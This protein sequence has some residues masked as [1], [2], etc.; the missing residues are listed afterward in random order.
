MKKKLK[1]YGYCDN[2][3]VGFYR[4]WSIL[5]MLKK[6]DLAEVKTAEYKWSEGDVQFP[7]ID[8]LADIGEWADI[9][10]FQRHDLG[11]YIA[12]FG[13]LSELFNI[14]FILE[15]DDNVRFVRPWNP[16]YRGYNPQGEALIWHRKV[17]EKVHGVIV[18]TR[19]LKEFHAKD[20]KYI[21]IC[22]NSLDM[23]LRD[24]LPIPDHPGEIRI[25]WLGSAA[26]TENL[27][28][29]LEP[30][31]Q[32]LRDYPQTVFYFQNM[33]QNFYKAMPKDI[34]ARVRPTEWR[35]MKEWGGYIAGLG[36]DI[37][38]APLAD[39]MFNRAKSNLRWMEYSINK[40]AVIVSP[41]KAYENVIHLETGMIAKEPEEWYENM[42]ILIENE[43]F[44][45]QIGEN[46]YKS[47][48]E[49]YDLE[50]NCLL[51]LKVFGETVERYRRQKGKKIPYSQKKE[52]VQKVIEATH[53][54]LSTAI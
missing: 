30:T 41:V 12:V 13:A 53:S 48:K 22:P 7:T 18:S 9:I 54:K 15:T 4:V 32:I 1:I 52:Q 29:I 33:Y 50:K 36:L 20:H 49:N 51:W 6:L 8:E 5:M 21:T 28:P 35:N 45:K 2:T 23:S 38:L 34:K 39:N 3:G 19:E 40:T 25:G 26:H 11:N 37:G 43:S 10:L 46:A 14:P 42:K 17:F 47:V 31:Y 44:R 27:K 16:G 24:N